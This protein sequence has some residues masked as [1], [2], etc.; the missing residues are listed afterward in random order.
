[1]PS[2]HFSDGISYDIYH[3]IIKFQLALP[4]SCE[5]DDL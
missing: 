3:K 1:M 2:D 4:C 5:F